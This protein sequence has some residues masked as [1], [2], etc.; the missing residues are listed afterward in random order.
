MVFFK[1]L[2]QLCLFFDAWSVSAECH[3][4]GSGLRVRGNAA[5]MLNRYSM[6]ADYRKGAFH[7]QTSA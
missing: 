4:M 5:S 3:T 2:E 6:I 7:P 1:F